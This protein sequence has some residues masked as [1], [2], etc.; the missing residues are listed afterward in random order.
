MLSGPLGTLAYLALTDHPGTLT[1]ETSSLR[2]HEGAAAPSSGQPGND[3]SPLS[4][5]ASGADPADDPLQDRI[6][7]ARRSLPTLASIRSE[8]PADLHGA[9]EGVLHA[10]AAIGELREHLLR[11]PEEFARASEFFAECAENRE[12]LPAIRAL[13]LHS[14]KERPAQWAPGVKERMEALPAPILQLES[15]L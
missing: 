15:Q 10:G 4:L 13:C 11:H 14:A 8:M 6:A 7:T 12:V 9:P 2:P 3:S 5:P 1:T